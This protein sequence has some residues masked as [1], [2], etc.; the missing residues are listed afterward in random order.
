[1][2]LVVSVR[3]EALVAMLRGYPDRL[4]NRLVVVMNRLTL[5]IQ[6]QVKG[7]KLSGQVLHTQT[8]TLRRSINR[9]VRVVPGMVE[10]TVGTNVEY[11]GAHEFGFSGRVTV[12]AHIRTIKLAFGRQLKSPIEVSVGSFSRSAN[13]PERSF[14]RSTLTEWNDRA[15]AA[16]Q[17]GAVEALK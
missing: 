2:R 9:E 10:G 14:L 17:Q 13:L 15:V 4:V 6:S 12:R 16:I 1:V 3:Q 8:G 7:F 11:A 5:E